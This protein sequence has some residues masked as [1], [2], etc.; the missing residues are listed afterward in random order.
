MTPLSEVQ[1]LAESQATARVDALACE[2]V[3]DFRR[4]SE[5]STGWDR[6]WESDPESEFFQSFAWA[7]AWWNSFGEGLKLFVPVVY[8]DGEV[9]LILPEPTEASIPGLT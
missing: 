2:V 5:L 1:L 8:E 7:R 4:L 6:L 3:T 9:A